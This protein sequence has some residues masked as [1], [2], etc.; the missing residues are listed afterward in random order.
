MRNWLKNFQPFMRLED[1]LK[2]TQQPANEF[3]SEPALFILHTRRCSLTRTH[4]YKCHSDSLL[5]FYN[6]FS[7]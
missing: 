1:F 4:K 5:I 3:Y 6:T 2:R 7:H